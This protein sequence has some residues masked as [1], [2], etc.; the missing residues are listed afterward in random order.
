[1]QKRNPVVGSAGFF[2]SGICLSGFTIS[3]GRAAKVAGIDI[4]H[5]FCLIG[6]S[7]LC[8]DAL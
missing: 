2:A 1:L 3:Y 8:A 4:R 5:R 6:L 7:Q